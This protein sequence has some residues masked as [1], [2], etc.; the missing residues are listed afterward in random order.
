[1]EDREESFT[2]KN[3]LQNTIDELLQSNATNFLPRRIEF[4][5]ARK[6][7]HLE[8]LRLKY[9]PLNESSLSTTTPPATTTTPAPSPQKINIS[10]KEAKV[11]NTL[12]KPE[13]S[14]FSKEEAYSL[15]EWHKVGRLGPGLMNLGNTCFLNS[16]LQCI[17]YC[18]P[19]ANYFLAHRHSKI[20]E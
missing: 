19:L 6:P 5:L 12:P 15:L 1:M 18:P 8:S 2:K 3:P 7:D 4:H 9:T 13:R 17:T 20:C 14:L 11:E 10:T 16:A